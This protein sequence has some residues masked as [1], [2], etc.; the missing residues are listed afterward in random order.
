MVYFQNRSGDDGSTGVPAPTATAAAYF[1]EQL[2]EEGIALMSAM[3]I[4]GFDADL[5]LSVFPGLEPQDFEAVAAFEG[6]Y[7][8]RMGEAVFERTQAE[9][10]SSAERTISEAGM[11]TLLANVSE[12][13][14]LPA[15]TEQEVELIIESLKGEALGH[16]QTG[17]AEP[18]ASEMAEI[19]DLIR[20]E[21]PLVGEAI[22]SPLQIRGEA[23]GNWYFEATFP[24]V[25]T[26]WDGRIIAETFATA[27]GGW[28]TTDFVPFTAT[29]EFTLPEESRVS[30]RGALILQKSNPS[31]LAEHDRALEL[32]IEFADLL[33]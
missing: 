3:P 23:R 25:L 11:R 16:S 20:L 15:T 29:V 19:P 30:P 6:M 26:D 33:P 13:L 31:G 18:V 5:Y 22:T 17:E 28:M 4:E 2:P 32:P 1:N 8:Y 14:N 12:R 9:P 21:R 27:Q 10:V 7:S 24:V